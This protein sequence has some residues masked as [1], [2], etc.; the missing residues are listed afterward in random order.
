MNEANGQVSYLAKGPILSTADD[1]ILGKLWENHIKNFE[2]RIGFNWALGQSQMTSLSGGFGIFHNQILHNSFVS[3]R[4]QLPLN[5]R[6]NARGINSSTAFPDI[7]AVVRSAGLS[8]RGTRAYDFENFKTPTFYRY[9]L[10]VQRQLPGEL[11]LRIGF[12]GAI[13]RHMARRQR[14]NAFPQHVVCPNELCPDQVADGARF[15]P[16]RSDAPQTINPDYGRIEWMSSDVNSTYSSMVASLQ[17]R[18]SRGLTFQANYTW[19]KSVDDYS[20]SETN[21]TGEANANPQFG[22]DRTLDRARSSF[23][24][25]HVFVMNGIYQLPFGPGKPFLNSGGAVSHIFGGW[26]IGGILT[27]QQG[28]PF[29]IGSNITGGGFSYRADRPN[30]KPGVDINQVTSGTSVG[31]V[32]VGAN[33]ITS[34]TPVG[35]RDLYFDPC[36]FSA[37]PRGTIGNAARNLIIGP[38]MRNVNFTLSKYFE[39]GERTRLQFRSEFF[40]LFNRVQLRNPAARVFTSLSGVRSS[41]G[42]ITESLDSSARQIQLGLKLTF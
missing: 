23:N 6:A 12:V 42:L 39:L 41:A 30:L 14:L 1:L 31:C 24:V 9:N 36:V 11:A 19:S 25:P 26:Q 35:T 2:P 3:F 5:F 32:V 38:D 40:N 18:F 22:P 13:G 7:E 20:Q 8:F 27:L 4:D 33:D 37:P 34:G 21:F 10:T 28:L 29:T 17:R 16:S 15:F